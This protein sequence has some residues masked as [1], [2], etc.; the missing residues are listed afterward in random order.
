VE[1]EDEFITNIPAGESV[2]AAGEPWTYYML[3][4][5]VVVR[6]RD[7]MRY[8]YVEVLQGETYELISE[9]LL[10]LITRPGVKWLESEGEGE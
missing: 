6:S 5:L 7:T 4:R 1:I 9:A 8:R 3:A 10:E 2:P